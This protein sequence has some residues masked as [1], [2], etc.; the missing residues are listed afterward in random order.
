VQ[1]EIVDVNDNAPEFTDKRIYNQISESAELETAFVIPAA[2][3]PD[4]GKNGIQKYDLFAT[5]NK[6]VLAVHGRA[7]GGTDLKIVLKEP[8][9][10]ETEDKYQVSNKCLVCVR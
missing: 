2:R 8:L 4:S 6:F 7:D 5:S 1:I 10:R 3:D 9:D